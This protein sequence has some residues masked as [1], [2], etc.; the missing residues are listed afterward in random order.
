MAHNGRANG[1]IAAG[2]SFGQTHYVW[3]EVPMLARE[4]FSSPAKTGRY[5][6]HDEQYT[7]VLTDFCD[8][9]IKICW[10][11]PEANICQNRLAQESGPIPC[12]G[13][14]FKLFYTVF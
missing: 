1:R 2:K 9:R 3:L 13:K 4:K 5:F 8:L 6:I 11:D 10:R 12:P 14:L 7:V